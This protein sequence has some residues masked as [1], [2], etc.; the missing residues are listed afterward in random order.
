MVY[1]NCRRV[2]TLQS[3]YL[4]SMFLEELER[5]E[6]IVIGVSSVAGEC[7]AGTGSSVIL[8]SDTCSPWGWGGDISVL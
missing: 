1:S 6:G 7:W 3:V 2:N 5:S 4:T 8:T